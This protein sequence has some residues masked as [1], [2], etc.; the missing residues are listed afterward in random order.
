MNSYLLKAVVLAIGAIL[1][2]P[3]QGE[4]R[5]LLPKHSALPPVARFN[6]LQAPQDPQEQKRRESRDR[7]SHNVY[8]GKV[9]LDPGTREENDQAETVALTFIDGVTILKPGEHPDPP[10][11]P[12]S[13]SIIV[14]GRVTSGTAYVNEERTGIFSEYKVEI[15]E[16]L[17]PDLDGPISARDQITTWRPGGSLQFPA[18]HIRHFVVGGQGFPEAGVQYVLFLRRPDE[19]VKDYAISSA[20]SIKDKVVSP[21]DDRQDQT[22]FDGMRLIDFLD[23]LRYSLH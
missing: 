18:G 10:G 7:L 19:K 3:P 1:T 9:I 22:Q 11:L 15:S 17:K 8:T 13:G 2:L 12:I 23:K 14:I 21:L 4:L 16:V 5:K 20:F 6:E